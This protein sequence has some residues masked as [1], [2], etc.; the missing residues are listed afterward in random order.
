MGGRNLHEKAFDEATLAKLEIFE[1]YTKSWLPTFV[2][3]SS[4]VICI[5]DLFAGTGYDINGVPG[6]PIRILQVIKQFIGEIFR[7]NVKSIRLYLNE[8]EEEKYVLLKAA[9]EKF[10]AENKDVGRIVT[11]QIDQKDFNVIYP[12][13]LPIISQFPSLVFL[14]QNGVKFTNIENLL[15]LEKTSQTDFLFFISSS[16]FKRFGETKEFSNYL[17]I[18]AAVLKSN[19]YK[20]IHEVVVKAIAQQLP[21][22]T[23]LRLYPFSIKKQT[24][25]YGLVFGA[26]HPRAVEKFLNVVWEKN[27][28]NGIANFDINEDIAKSGLQFNLFAEPKR[29]KIEKF[30]EL[31]EST[32]Q[33][34]KCVTNKFMYLFTLEQGHP[35]KHANAHLKYLKKVGKIYYDTRTP[36]LGYKEAYKG[37]EPVS[38]NWV[39]VK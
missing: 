11:Y 5:F 39:N 2:M 21:T 13:L 25:I 15:K 38:I 26:K 8:Y 17:K 20:F 18:D 10:L 4:P 1:N 24:N 34:H 31:L 29:T 9:I 23:K 36:K 22:N 3:Q 6:S 19:P 32:L 16:Y 28:I 27:P 7:K 12:E 35:L 33:E 14:D 30:N 37:D